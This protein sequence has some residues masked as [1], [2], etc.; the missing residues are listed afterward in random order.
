MTPDALAAFART[1]LD[2]ALAERGDPA[3]SALAIFRRAAS[4]VPAYAAYL[5]AH[6]VDPAGVADLARVPLM[7]KDAYVAAHPLAERCRGGSLASLDTIAVS[8]G[9]TGEPTF[10][11]RSADDEL[12]VARRF[13]QVFV[14]SFGAAEKR[15]LA[16]VCFPLGTWVGGMFTTAACRHLASRGYQVTTV[17]PGNDRAEI[18]RVVRALAPAYDQ[19]VLLGYPPFVKDVV[20]GALADG[21][22]WAP[23]SIK[24]V[25][26]GEVFSEAWRTLVCERAALAR[27]EYDTASLY[28]TADAG[29]LAVETPLSIALRRFC[30][31]H[32][33]AARALFGSTRLPTLAQYDPRARY[34]E[35]TA[36]GTLVVTADGGAPLVRYHI[37]DDGGVLGFDA[38]LARAAEL[39]FEAP[40]SIRARRLPF[41]WVFGRSR[42]AISLYGANVFPEMI[43]VG[44]EQ[45]DVRA[46]VTGKFVMEARETDSRDRRLAI[47]VELAR[48]VSATEAMRDAI[49]GSILAELLRL[50]SEFSHYVPREVQRPEIALFAYGDP[51]RFPVGVKHRYSRR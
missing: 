22:S 17:T 12:A 32:L 15:T 34:F 51:A 42:F 19:T 46:W 35:T 20:D 23:A 13:E 24:L 16:V 28:G 8:S 38:M 36:E 30:D 2:E 40:P 27:P 11:P 1:S 44:L 9:S 43:S 6:G 26:A 33:D 14:D 31:V 49:A 25:L 18:L 45:P 39:G 29:V 3:E 7:T 10:W 48:G 47:D 37:A 4:T 41:V 21:F 5:R 50:D